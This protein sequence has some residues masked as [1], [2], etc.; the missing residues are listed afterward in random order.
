VRHSVPHSE[1]E[2]KKKKKSFVFDLTVRSTEIGSP[3]SQAVGKRRSLWTTGEQQGGGRSS[4]GRGVLTAEVNRRVQVTAANSRTLFR[5][6]EVEVD[7][8]VAAPAGWRQ[9]RLGSEPKTTLRENKTVLTRTGLLM[10]R[11]VKS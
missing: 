3:A 5:I 11:Q 1:A 9:R 8:Q 6:M 4:V 7:S 2:L 10:E